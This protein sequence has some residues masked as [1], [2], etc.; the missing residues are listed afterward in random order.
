M[1]EI[2]KPV[3]EFEGKYEISNL[4]QVRNCRRGNYLKIKQS[5]TY[6]YCYLTIDSKNSR[7]LNVVDMMDQLFEAHV[8]DHIYSVADLPGEEWRPVVGFETTYA[9]RIFT[10]S[11]QSECRLAYCLSSRYLFRCNSSIQ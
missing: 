5:G 1:E 8:Y 3:L 6:H 11:S 2:W 10:S 4:G 7:E 9:T